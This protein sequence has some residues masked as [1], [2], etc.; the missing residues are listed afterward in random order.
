VAEIHVE[1]TIAAPQ[2]RV[3]DWL[4]DAGTPPTYDAQG[5]RGGDGPGDQVGLRRD[6]RGCAKA[7]EQ[8]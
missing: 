2:N 6:P 3:F 1:R 4:A 8:A 7:L 5:A